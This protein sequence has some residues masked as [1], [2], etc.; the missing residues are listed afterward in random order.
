M[1]CP[2][3]YTARHPLYIYISIRDRDKASEHSL[4]T[5]LSTL[6][7]ALSIADLTFMQCKVILSNTVP[8]LASCLSPRWP[9]DHHLIRAIRARVPRTKSPPS[10]S[11]PKNQSDSATSYLQLHNIKKQKGRLPGLKIKC[12]RPLGVRF[13]QLAL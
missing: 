13:V 11:P 1:S 7:L 6:L 5:Y 3:A 4:H 12:Y 2:T 8:A 10:G 9:H